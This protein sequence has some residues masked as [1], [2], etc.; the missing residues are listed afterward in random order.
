MIKI[1]Y[2][3][4]VSAIAAACFVAL[5]TVSQQVHATPSAQATK[6][7]LADRF[8][9]IEKPARATA[10]ANAPCGQSAWPYIGAGC[11]RTAEGGALEPHVVRVVSADRFDNTAAR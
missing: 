2:A 4:A 7:S 1:L 9:P 10:A 8:A 6:S 3:V 11:L 5:P